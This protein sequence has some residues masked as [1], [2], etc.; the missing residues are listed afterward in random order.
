MDVRATP[1]PDLAILDANLAALERFRPESARFLRDASPP[2]SARLTAG[3]DGRPTFA[4]SEHDGRVQWLGRTSMPSISGAALVDAFQPGNRNVLLAGF[5]QGIEARLLLDRLAPHQAVMV[6][7]EAAWAVALGLRLYDF[8]ADFR[9]GRMP[10]F[11]GPDAWAALRDFLVTSDGYMT[12]ERVL[13]WPWF[14]A[15]TIAEVSAKLLEVG[16]HVARCSSARHAEDR[17]KRTTRPPPAPGRGIALVSNIAQRHVKR[18]ADRLSIA[19]E[20]LGRPC[21]RFVLNDPTMVR[22][23]GVERA[24][25]DASPGTVLLLDAA[26]ASLQ[27]EVPP[28]P[29][30][31]LCAHREPLAHDWISELPGTIK[32]SVQTQSQRQQVIDAGLAESRVLLMPPAALPGLARTQKEPGGR[33]LVLADGADISA[34]GVGLHLASHCQLWETATEIIRERCDT[35]NDDEAAAVLDSAE[36]KLKIKLDSDDVQAGIVDRLQR[37]LGPAIVRETYCAA[38]ADAGVDFDLCGDGWTADSIVSEHRRGPWPGPRDMPAALEGYGLV[39]S[40]EPSGRVRSAVLDGAAAGLAVAVRSHPL[41]DSVDGVA[42][43]LDPARHVW[44]FR[45]RVELVE[46]ARTFIR[47]PGEFRQRAAEASSQI[48]ASHTWA[49]RLQAIL[50]ACGS[51]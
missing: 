48:N 22:P 44:R 29:S 19:A 16:R 9:Q 15:K 39:I 46:V 49:H 6:V 18:L 51:L 1:T 25:F 21:V 37:I 28:V 31:V 40:I 43:V 38:L 30:I 42:A 2:A 26:P 24:L 41:D 17:Q 33:I 34:Q 11:I 32:L 27:Y 14:D 50:Q 13:S 47:K 45:S 3:R 10:L 7:E 23:I 4:W 5:G 8:S 20:S 12:P 36:R 35:Y